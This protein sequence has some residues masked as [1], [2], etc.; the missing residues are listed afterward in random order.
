MLYAIT[1]YI[2]LFFM[3]LQAKEKSKSEFPPEVQLCSTRHWPQCHKCPQKLHCIDYTWKIYDI[4]RNGIVSSHLRAVR[5]LIC[6]P[7]GAPDSLSFFPHIE[8]D[9]V[10]NQ[11]AILEQKTVRP[12]APL[13]LSW[14]GHFAFFKQLC[15]CVSQTVCK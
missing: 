5:R 3:L 11:Q 14:Q 7:S 9:M 12:L 8:N 6:L 13:L 2:P 1:R 4:E 10:I 15:V